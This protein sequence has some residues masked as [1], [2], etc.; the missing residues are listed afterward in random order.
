MKVETWCRKMFS[1]ESRDPENCLSR[2]MKVETGTNKSR[3]SMKVENENCLSRHK[4]KRIKI[5]IED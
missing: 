3:S 2:Q 4:A 1:N 5:Q